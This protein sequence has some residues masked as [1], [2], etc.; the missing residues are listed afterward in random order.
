MAKRAKLKHSPEDPSTNPNM[1]LVSTPQDAAD[2][3]DAILFFLH[4]RYAGEDLTPDMPSMRSFLVDK[5]DIVFTST[6]TSVQVEKKPEKNVLNILTPIVP[7]DEEELRRIY[8]LSEFG[9]LLIR[10]QKEGYQQVHSMLLAI[11]DDDGKEMLVQEFKKH[12]KARA[13]A[14]NASAPKKK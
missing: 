14:K 4:R 5:M 2:Q 10:T 12:R 9:E 3:I 11:L 1:N 8:L 7:K 13:T 6:V